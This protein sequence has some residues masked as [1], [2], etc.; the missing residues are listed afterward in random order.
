MPHHA[1]HV[2]KVRV[3]IRAA[4]KFS[5]EAEFVVSWAARW[6]SETEI[7]AASVQACHTTGCQNTEVSA[8]AEEKRCSSIK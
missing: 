8:A 2:I 3:I 5:N 6:S 7:P 4:W 1:A